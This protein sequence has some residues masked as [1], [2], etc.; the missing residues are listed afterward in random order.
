MAGKRECR[1][2]PDRFCYICGKF[3]FSDKKE[4]SDVVKRA[5]FAYF[6]MPLGDQDKPWAPHVVCCTCYQLL[7]Q[8]THKKPNRHLKFGIPMVWR[9]Q[10]DHITDCYFCMVKTKGFNTKNRHKIEYPSLPSAILPVPH[11]ELNP[12]P[13]F[14]KLPPLQTTPFYAIQQNPIEDTEASNS[15][16]QT[17]DEF[18]SETEDS[19]GMSTESEFEYSHS[20]SSNKSQSL[21]QLFNQ[22]KLND[23]IRDLNLSK[24][25]SLVL[26]SRLKEKTLLS[27]GTSVAFY[28]ERKSSFQQF[29]HA[30]DSFVFCPNIENLL[31]E[32]GIETYDASEWRLFIDS[33]KRSLK[34]VL[35][36]NGNRFGSIPLAHSVHAKE[37]YGQVKT[38]LSL[39]NYHDHEWVICVDLKMVNFL[40]GQQGGFTKYP[41]FLCYWDSRARNK[42]WTQRD[43]EIREDLIVGEQNVINEALVDRNKII[44]PPLHIKLGLMKQLVKALDKE[45]NCFG[46]LRSSFPGVSEEKVK[47]GIFDGPQI[48][49][50]IND[51]KFI[52]SMN[53]EEKY[54]WTAFVDVVRDFLGPRKAENYE[55][56]VRRLLESYQQLGCNMSIK[57]HFLFSH[58]EQ[59][60]DNLGDYSDEQG[61]RFH[62]DLKMMEERYKGRWDI[63]MMADFCWSIKRDEPFKK[64]KRL[65][66]KRRFIPLS[67]QK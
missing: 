62:Q 27:P 3:T 46:Y 35:L 14:K 49:K 53:E 21:P 41:C 63:N 25:Q 31:L 52:D 4:I 66:K 11:S 18:D 44:F 15:E 9:E 6:G 36:H 40:L 60:P 42:H 37:D 23:L 48:R 2:S 43:W 17:D 20:V 1:N 56:L 5:Y 39:I 45:G 57:I 7:L 61:E 51:V 38:V 47:N 13:V 26:A 34:C 22:F 8:W 16:I 65:S 30:K 50:M 19:E 67:E 64:H 10:S 24:D 29:Y 59:F 32:L 12:V 55:E 28:K 33:S 54:E 58:L